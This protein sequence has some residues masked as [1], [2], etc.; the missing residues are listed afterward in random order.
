M[1]HWPFLLFF[2]C[3]TTILSANPKAEKVSVQLQ[4]ADQFQFAGYYVAKEKGFYKEA[5]LDVTIKKFDPKKLAIDE[6]TSGKVEYGIGRSSLL[7]DRMRG[8]DV[9]ALAAI[10]QRSPFILLSE[11]SRNIRTPKDLIGKRVMMTQDFQDTIAVRAMLNSQG[12]RLDQLR[13]QMH[14]YN[15][16]DIANGKT[17]V[18]ACYISNEPFVLK[19]QGIETNA[20]SPEEFGFGFYSD[21]LFTSG[22]EVRKHPK[23]V[24]AF[25]DATLKGWEYA[26]AHIDETAQLIKE[27]YNGQ[28]KSFESLVYEGKILKDLA[29]QGNLPLGSMSLDKFRRISDIYRVMGIPQNEE[30]LVGFLYE[31]ASA[32][33]IP[34]S[35]QERSFL[36][37]HTIRSISTSAWPP[38]NFR[39]G[40]D[41]TKLYGIANDFW[42]VIVKRTGMKTEF[43]EAPIWAAVLDA[44]QNKSADVTLGTSI[45]PAKQEY[46]IFSKPYASFPNVIVTDKKIDFLPGL[47]ALSGKKV[48]IGQRY[49]VAELISKTYPSIRIVS[50]ED[51]T[52]ALRLLSTGEVDAVVDI[53]PVVAYLINANHLLDLKISGTT[54]FNF[55]VRIMIRNDYPQLK[56]IIDKAIDSISPAERQKIFNRYISVTYEE[57]TDYSWI[58][59]FAAIALAIIIFFVYRQFEM[60]KYNRKLL[61]MAT[62]DPLTQIANRIRLDEQLAS[63]HQICLRTQRPY[64]IVIMDMDYFKQVNDTYGHLIGDKALIAVARILQNSVRDT[65]VVGRWGGEE[66][67]IICPETSLKGAEHVARKIQSAI[68]AYDFEGAR[69]LTCSFGISQCRQGDKLEN[70][71]ARADNALY[72]AK[73][74]GRNRI[75]DQ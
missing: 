67:M 50:A 2:V 74:E 63:C 21:I 25:L 73:K 3:F 48:A 40:G 22:E 66:F 17:D 72:Q 54:E 46:A 55:D 6:V 43:T 70:V 4:W 35:I 57:K 15:P 29:Y 49:G 56:A 58:Y 31:D 7:I 16:A 52:E 44:I 5:G 32:Q 34:L 62:T 65:D 45:S 27:R 36:H 8:K 60:G 19:E 11:K 68:S 14:S 33:T 59:R 69:T 1:K 20:I 37:M 23:R 47:S 30:R 24:R 9:V 26:F 75:C 64:S 41:D 61:K 12:V 13:F 71:V 38:F 53:L 42:D 39:M 18:M 10:F 51:T 28:N